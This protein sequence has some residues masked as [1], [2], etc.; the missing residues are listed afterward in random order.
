MASRFKGELMNGLKLLMLTAVG[1]CL[2]MAAAPK[3]AAQ[4]A[5][6]I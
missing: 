4:V 3:A 2:M 5:M 1:G 6:E